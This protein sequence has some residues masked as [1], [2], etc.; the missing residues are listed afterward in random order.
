MPNLKTTFL[1]LIV[2]VISLGLIGCGM[3]SS[4]EEE[5]EEFTATE[6]GKL[7]EWLL[8]K[9]RSSEWEEAEPLKPKDPEN[10]ED[11]DN[12]D[13]DVA[14]SEL[15]EET[16]ETEPTQAAQRQ[17]QPGQEQSVETE[18]QAQ[19]P[20][21]TQVSNKEWQRGK[22]TGSWLESNPHGEGTFEH[23]DGGKISGTWVKG[24]PD[25]QFTKTDPDG[26]T[27]T[28]YFS[29]GQV[30]EGPAEEEAAE[31]RWWEQ[32]SSSPSGSTFQLD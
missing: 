11:E 16:T 19:E 14:E 21:I 32:E 10:D 9:H 7:P 24:N 6:E 12:E 25:G 2:L 26:T 1:T 4:Q 3:L 30:Q 5:P 27:E 23:P 13:R 20:E 29:Q 8:L 31:S 15:P 22:Y 18:D 28:V 17:E